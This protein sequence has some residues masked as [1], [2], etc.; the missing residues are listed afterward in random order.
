MPFLLYYLCFRNRANSFYCT[1]SPSLSLLQKE[2]QSYLP[3]L[4]FFIISLMIKVKF[5]YRTLHRDFSKLGST[6]FLWYYYYSSLFELL[7]M[8]HFLLWNHSHHLGVSF[9]LESKLNQ[10]LR[11]ASLYLMGAFPDRHISPHIILFWDQG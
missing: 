6:A 10:C 2:G 5:I 4:I 7:R 3:N 8:E 9:Q 11:K 1:L